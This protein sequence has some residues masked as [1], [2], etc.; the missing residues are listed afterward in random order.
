MWNIE[1]IISKGD[2]NYAVVPKHP[3]ASKYG[4]VLEH[5]IVVE[6][7]LGRLLDDYEVVHHIDGNKKHN[8]IN[9]LDICMNFEHLRI[10]GLKQ[11]KNMAVLKCPQCG[12]IFERRIGQTFLVK[13]NEYTCCCISCR[14]KFSRYI[15]LNG[16]TKAVE[17]AISGNLVS[18][19]NTSD[20]NREQTF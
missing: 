15:Q 6:N 5:R 14:G 19:Y 13:S 17:C 16:R 20:D 12:N 2:Y 18:L 1:K 8:D 11:G 10:H 7:Y 4:Y 9:N 3:N